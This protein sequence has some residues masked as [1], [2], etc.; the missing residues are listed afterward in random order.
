[1][2]TFVLVLSIFAS[3]YLFGQNRINAYVE[4]LKE[5]K[6]PKEYIFQ[7]WEDADIIVLGERDHRDTTQYN[8]ILDILS[9]KRFIEKV[10]NLYLEVGVVNATERANDLIKNSHDKESFHKRFVELQMI[11]M[12]SPSYWDK[13]NRYQLL[14]GLF[15][16]NKELSRENQINIGLLDMEFSWHDS[17]TPKKYKEFYTIQMNREYNTREK[18]MADN[19][20]TFYSKQQPR[21]NHKK[22][23]IITSRE[24]ARKFHVHCKGNNVKRQA[25]HIKD[26][27]GNK[28]KTVALNW[29]KWLPLNW[30]KQ[31]LPNKSN[32]LSADGKFDAAFELTNCTAVGFDLDASPFGEDK[33]DYTF[34]NDLKWKDVFDGYI[35]YEPYYNFTGKIGFPTRLNNKQAKEFIRRMIINNQALGNKKDARLLKWFGWIRKYTEKN[36][37]CNMREFKCISIYP[38]HIE[39][40]S[41]M[42]KWIISNEQEQ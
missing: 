27:Y 25:G 22:A 18:I 11:E 32:G 39:W 8:L 13:Y 12:W 40:K 24:Y 3:N 21:N 28:V 2:R 16:I 6:S 23:L 10:G 30:E 35:F 20:Q 36:E 9:D 38:N 42:D 15:R 31:I 17:I 5:Q 26:M 29:Y 1:M 41:A 19:F 37:Y 14:Y 33:Y 34:D 7:L 4:F